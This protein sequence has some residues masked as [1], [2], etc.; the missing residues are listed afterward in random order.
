[1]GHIWL[2]PVFFQLRISVFRATI[3]DPAHRQ[4]NLLP[5]A[6]DEITGF[7][8]MYR[9]SDVSRFF[10]RMGKSYHCL[11]FPVQSNPMSLSYNRIAGQNVER[12]AAL[13]DGIFAVSMTLLVMDL[14]V[15]LRNMVHSESDLTKAL[16][17]LS[18]RIVMY[19][20]SFLTLGI[21]WVG[22]QTQLNFLEK[23][24]RSLAWIHLLFL[25]AVTLTPFST[26]LLAGYPAFRVALLIYWINI[27][28]LGGALFLSWN[29]AMKLGLLKGDM[30]REV[31]FAIKRRILIA[32]G[33]YAMGAFLCLF[34]MHLAI[35]F[36]FAVQ[37]YY[38][39]APRLG[40]SS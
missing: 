29:C 8:R 30:D 2:K 16:I 32:Q 37:M 18:P 25:F 14:H 17:H 23:S 3:G 24:H 10:C 13:S 20:M 36:I 33:L 12:L 26:Q 7:Y 28:L 22:Q 34:S 35:G 6:F 15:P 39:I 21:F 19:M 11:F 9:R 5:L 27:L 1:M 40:K 31:P 38:A 4:R